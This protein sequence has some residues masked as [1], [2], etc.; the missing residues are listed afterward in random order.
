MN[1]R[2]VHFRGEGREGHEGHL[3]YTRWPIAG[4]TFQLA[5]GERPD[6]GRY[7]AGACTA[8]IRTFLNYFLERDIAEPPQASG[9]SGGQSACAKWVTPGLRKSDEFNRRALGV[10][11]PHPRHHVGG[12]ATALQELPHDPH[13]G[14]GVGE[15]QF[16]SRA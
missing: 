1:A 16:Q 8:V 15:K 6:K 7:R 12:R 13:E 4:L 5:D 14:A 11:G 2:R 9:R 10:F 3:R